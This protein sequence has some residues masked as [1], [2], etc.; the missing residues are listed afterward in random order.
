M[1]NLWWK[2]YRIIWCKNDS[3]K[4]AF[5][6]SWTYTLVPGNI[7]SKLLK[8]KLNISSQKMNLYVKPN[9]CI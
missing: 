9:F 4:G 1:N 2:F 6:H 5:P 3:G 8:N 7:G